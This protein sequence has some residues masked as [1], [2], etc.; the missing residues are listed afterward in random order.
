MDILVFLKLSSFGCYVSKVCIEVMFKLMY[1]SHRSF[2]KS[3]PVKYEVPS[4]SESSSNDDWY[5][6]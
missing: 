1:F 2:F 4:N 6:F 5:V 3:A